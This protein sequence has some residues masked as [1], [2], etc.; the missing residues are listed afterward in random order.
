MPYIAALSGKVITHNR[1]YEFAPSVKAI[2]SQDEAISYLDVEAKSLSNILKPMLNIDINIPI[3]NEQLISNF[4][5]MLFTTNAD[6]GGTVFREFL[7]EFL[8]KIE[9]SILNN[10]FMKSTPLYVAAENKYKDIVALLMENGAY[11][12]K[13]SDNGETPLLASIY[14]GHHDIAEI[15]LKC[16]ADPLVKSSLGDAIDFA[17][18]YSYWDIDL[19]KELSYVAFGKIKYTREDCL[20]VINDKVEPLVMTNYNITGAL[21]KYSLHS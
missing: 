18:E 16:G 5:N 21:K 13:G 20:A 17:H 12:N 9:I 6:Y 7:E 2:L 19:I 14:L 15:L 4:Q 8:P 10:S 11:I 1:I 3:Y